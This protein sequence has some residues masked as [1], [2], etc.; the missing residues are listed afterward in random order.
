[1]LERTTLRLTPINPAIRPSPR[2]S[3][4]DNYSL[5]DGKLS[6]LGVIPAFEPGKNL[7]VRY[8]LVRLALVSLLPG[9]L[10]LGKLA[11]VGYVVATLLEHV[12]HVALPLKD[13]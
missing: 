3:R 2:S 13:W 6:N 1:M 5:L 9:L 8:F 10:Q 4:A 11:H 12:L 7:L